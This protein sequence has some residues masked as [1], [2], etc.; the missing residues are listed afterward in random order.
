MTDIVQINNG[1]LLSKVRLESLNTTIAKVNELINIREATN[2]S[3]KYFTFDESSNRVIS[4]KPIETTLQ[5][6][7]LGK[8]H[9]ISSGGE[10][11][12]FSNEVSGYHYFP[13]WGALHMGTPTDAHASAAGVIHPT[14]NTYDSLLKSITRTGAVLAPA[15]PSVPV[16]GSYTPLTN[17]SI[18]AFTLY[19]KQNL[20]AGNVV[21][22]RAK[23]NSLSN[24]GQQVTIYEDKFE[25]TQSSGIN[26]EL[27]FWMKGPIEL[28]KGQEFTLQA[29]VQ[30]SLASEDA[31]V[32]L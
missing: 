30:D 12:F 7:H 23:I 6:L 22:F 24:P 18:Q 17:L 15:A 11:I 26:T 3:A 16:D 2:N 31:E 27:T 32:T 5:S 19:S 13:P 14:I 9:T 20:Y 10:N 25:V 4:S 28:H 21:N 29:T 8:V 1:D